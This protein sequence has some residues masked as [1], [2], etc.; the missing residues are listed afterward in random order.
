MPAAS[1]RPL[2]LS[3]LGVIAVLGLAAL[4]V[5]VLAPG[6]AQAQGASFEGGLAGTNLLAYN[7]F[8]TRHKA[9]YIANQYGEE[10]GDTYQL[11]QFRPV[12]PRKV[13]FDSAEPPEVT[14]QGEHHGYDPQRDFE[15]RFNVA[16][17]AGLSGDVSVDVTVTQKNYVKLTDIS[18]GEITYDHLQS[19]RGERCPWLTALFEEKKQDG[20]HLLIKSIFYASGRLESYFKLDTKVSASLSGGQIEEAVAKLKDVLA[21]LRLER[22]LPETKLE[23]ALSGKTVHLSEDIREFRGRK[24]VAFIPYAVNEKAMERYLEVF[25]YGQRD[26]ELDT[27]LRLP[28][29][30][31]RFLNEY[32]EFSFEPGTLSPL[33]R[34]G[35][36]VVTDLENDKIAFALESDQ[37]LALINVLAR[38]FPTT[39][40]PR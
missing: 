28:E 20:E 25:L 24:P 18:L 4:G 27:A 34:G 12:I 17:E 32:P 6:R 13:C 35:D 8:R 19:Y 2:R 1:A 23:A 11:P 15:F 14:S 3:I 7:Y 9:Y 38:Q 26:D 29:N 31:A 40:L 16:A 37:K 10:A 33:L 5:G 30:A 36:A 21:V 22:L 39:D